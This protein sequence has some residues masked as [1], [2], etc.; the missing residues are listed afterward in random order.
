[1]EAVKV[2]S[3]TAYSAVVDARDIRHSGECITGLFVAVITFAAVSKSAYDPNAPSAVP[4]ELI[5]ACRLVT[6]VEPAGT[7]IPDI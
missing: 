7:K 5:P 1:M 4:D 6:E 2:A 3:V